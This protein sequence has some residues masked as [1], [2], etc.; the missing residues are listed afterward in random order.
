MGKYANWTP[1]YCIIGECKSNPKECN[2]IEIVDGYE[3]IC[4]NFRNNEY[5]CID[6]PYREKAKDCP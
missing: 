6:G 2:K 5:I 4:N 3:T 1:Y